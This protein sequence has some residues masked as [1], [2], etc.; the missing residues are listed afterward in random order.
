M[1][2][3]RPTPLNWSSRRLLLVGAIGLVLWFLL[4]TLRRAE[5]ISTEGGGANI[6]FFVQTACGFGGIVAI[7]AG[8]RARRR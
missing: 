7:I 6:V 3:R 8:L 5:G 1:T 4:L 2:E